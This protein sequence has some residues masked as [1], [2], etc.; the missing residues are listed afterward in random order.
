METNYDAPSAQDET[1]ETDSANEM[2]IELQKK[3]NEITSS[4][5]DMNTS[6]EKESFQ[7]GYVMFNWILIFLLTLLTVIDRFTLNLWPLGVDG[8]IPDGAD[9]SVTLFY[10]AAQISG[11]MMLVSSSYI[12][13][14]ENDI[15]WNWFYEIY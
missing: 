11:R 6:F 5:T 9:W 8:S 4:E 1:D 13:L 10:I 2:A 14:F 7:I 12:L 15:F 3:T